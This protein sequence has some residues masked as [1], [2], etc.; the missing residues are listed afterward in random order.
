MSKSH[1]EHFSTAVPQKAHVV[2]NAANGSFVPEEEIR[3]WLAR[4]CALG[5]I[6]SI[7]MAVGTRIELGVNLGQARPSLGTITERW[8]PRGL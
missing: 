4:E 3:S 2:L 7:E 6:C 1:S 5:S 8:R